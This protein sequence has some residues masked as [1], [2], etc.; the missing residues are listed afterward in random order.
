MPELLHPMSG[1]GASD[2]FLHV[3][4]K[5][6]GKLKGEAIS[7]GHEDDIEVLGWSWGLSAGSAMGSGRATAKRSYKELSV[8]KAIDAASTALMAAL[9]TNDEVREARLSMRKAGGGQV[10]YFS[11]TL[12]HARVVALQHAVDPGGT[13]HETVS[14]AFTRVKVE[15]RPQQASGLAGGARTFEDELN[16][17]AA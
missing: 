8:V 16:E 1:A 9:V 5:R 3:Q 17:A 4:T 13:T 12:S 6:A 11:I 15:Y 14:F 2:I 7:Q 10:D